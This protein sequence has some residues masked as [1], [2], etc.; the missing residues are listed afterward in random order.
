MH[1][2]VA[3]LLLVQQELHNKNHF[4]ILATTL[5]LMEEYSEL[6]SDF[7]KTVIDLTMDDKSVAKFVDLSKD[8]EVFYLCSSSSSSAG[9]LTSSLPSL[10]IMPRSLLQHGVINS[11]N[12]ANSSGSDISSA[13]TN[14]HPGLPHPQEL[15]GTLIRFKRQGEDVSNS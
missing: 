7:N 10:G 1:L 6:D 4:D 5:K 13:G 8:L 2:S 12:S 15:I 9:S 3:Y 11:N 14:G